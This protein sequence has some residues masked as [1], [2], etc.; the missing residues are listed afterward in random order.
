MGDFALPTRRPTELARGERLSS[1]E[2]LARRVSMGSARAFAVLYRRHH[3]A[4]YRYCRSIVHDE[5]DAQ[6]ALQSAMMRALAAFAP[7]NRR[8]YFCFRK[9]ACLT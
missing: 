1:D 2:W 3:Q 5:D 6:D 4:L 7:V 8:S 9:P